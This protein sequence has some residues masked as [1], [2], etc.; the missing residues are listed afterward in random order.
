MIGNAA[1]RLQ[2]KGL[3]DALRH[4]RLV[5]YSVFVTWG[6]ALIWRGSQS[7]Q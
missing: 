7:D 6:F 1:S 3:C 2:G 4:G 5:Y